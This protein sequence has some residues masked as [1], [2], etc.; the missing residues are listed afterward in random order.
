VLLL[1]SSRAFG[2][3]LAARLSC[4]PD[5]DV[6][7]VAAPS[8]LVGKLLDGGLVDVMICD[9][10]IIEELLLKATT[11]GRSPLPRIVVL[12]DRTAEHRVADVVRAGAAGW[13]F[14][15][16]SIKDLL[17]TVRGVAQGETWIPP[18]LLTTLIDVLTKD[19]RR[20]RNLEA[21]FETLT[22][23]EMDVLTCLVHG[24]GRAQIAGRLNI[25]MNTV[26]TH[27]Q[28]MLDKLGVHS[29][30]AAVVLARRAGIGGVVPRG[31]E[32]LGQSS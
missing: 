17:A 25:S 14:R 20:R 26:R 30:L 8:R 1:D 18:R 9:E 10:R 24:L 29:T 6:V 32:R 21:Q 27:V 12:A 7:G 19:E 28:N 22:P 11:F 3:A 31:I 23:R 13:V 15:E 16:S 5:L 2:E 4:E